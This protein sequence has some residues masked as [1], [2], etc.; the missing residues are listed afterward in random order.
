M[1]ADLH[2]DLIDFRSCDWRGQLF[3]QA[4]SAGASLGIGSATSL[5]T[6]HC[7]NNRS[8]QAG[9]ANHTTKM[10]MR[11]AVVRFDKL[12]IENLLTRHA[13]SE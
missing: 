4:A 10:M 6:T 3:L 5:V 12:F 7:Q 8:T 11:T 13:I 9:N 2:S 1:S